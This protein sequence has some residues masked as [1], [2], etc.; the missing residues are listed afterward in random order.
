M[1][2]DTVSNPKETGRGRSFL[3]VTASIGSGHI[4]AA[5]SVAEA[6]K[7]K[8]PE[9]SVNMV[10]FTAAD[11]SLVNAFMKWSYLTM[12]KFVPNLYELMYR[13]TGHRT[14][15]GII[16]AFLDF[17]MARDMRKLVRKYRPDAVICTHPFPSGAASQLKLYVKGTDE[18]FLSDVV[19]T[20]YSVHQ[21]WVYKRVDQYF[22]AREDMCRNLADHGLEKST[23]YPVGIPVGREFS[24][25]ESRQELFK[26]FKLDSS[27]P[28]LL[29]MGG[30]LGLGGMDVALKALEDLSQDVQIIV[31]AGKNQKLMAQ[32]QAVIPKSH[33]DIRVYGYTDMVHKLMMVSSLLISKPGA[34]TITE[35]MS[36]GLPILLH[37]PIPGPE[38]DNAEYFAQ[39]G[40]AAW[41]PKDHEL[42]EKVKELLEHPKALEDM[43]KAAMHW[44]RPEAAEK[45]ADYIGEALKSR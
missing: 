31:V 10:D 39:C 27:K 12:L 2:Q 28:V 36:C 40:T 9:A 42:G 35:A 41:I 25:V 6:L 20:D 23:L 8:Y 38:T 19:I 34:L 16:Q 44:R 33:H 43:R 37:E 11:V 18:D 21:M 24:S 30:G 4:K 5:S 45:I 32:V 15:G 22:V 1:E 13:V 3:L 29:I 7:I 17:I 26:E 14:G